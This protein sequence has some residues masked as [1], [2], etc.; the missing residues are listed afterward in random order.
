MLMYLQT[1]WCNIFAEAVNFL[2][3][4]FKEYPEGENLYSNS[5]EKQTNNL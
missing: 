5:L 3:F 2:F 4:G 1:L